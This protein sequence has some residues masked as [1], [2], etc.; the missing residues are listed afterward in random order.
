MSC[1][2]ADP[3]IKARFLAT[4]LKRGAKI[5]PSWLRNQHAFPPSLP[6]L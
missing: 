2:Q 4:M 1:E 6:L 5:H 3:N